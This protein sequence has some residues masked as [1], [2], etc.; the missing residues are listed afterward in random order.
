MSKASSMGMGVGLA[1]ALTL[2]GCAQ[3]AP[4]PHTLAIS[5]TAEPSLPTASVLTTQTPDTCKILAEAGHAYTAITQPMQLGDIALR[6][7]IPADDITRFNLSVLGKTVFSTVLQNGVGCIGLPVSRVKN[8]SDSQKAKMNYVSWRAGC[9]SSPGELRRVYVPYV[10]FEGVS[11][12]GALDVNKAVANDIAKIF[13]GIYSLGF[14]LDSVKPLEEVTPQALSTDNLS[15]AE[16]I[17]AH[18]MEQNNTSAFNCRYVP[19]KA[20]PAISSHGYGLAVDINPLQNPFLSLGGTHISPSDGTKYVNRVRVYPGMLSRED[21]VG[22]KVIA[23][24]TSRGWIWGGDFKG[25]DKDWQHFYK[26]K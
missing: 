14:P 18:S 26:K 13:E 23:L 20:P 8:L 25:S 7:A 5:R 6:E 12:T 24:F 4:V 11:K 3:E 21:A 10:D 17:D 22:Q 1:V 16:K 15:E 19:D 2:S 9:L